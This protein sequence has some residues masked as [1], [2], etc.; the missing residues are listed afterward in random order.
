[1]LNNIYLEKFKKTA[2]TLKTFALAHKII[3]GFI[4]L[5]IIFIGYWIYGK[6]ISTATETQYITT[7]V[8]K[9]SIISSITASGQVESS[10]KIDLKAN[11]SGTITYVSVKPGDKVLQGKTLFIIDNKD[12]QKSVRDAEINLES[13]KISLNKLKIQ[14]SA[15][16]MNTDLA[17]AYDD[18]FNTVSNVFL[19]LPGIMTGLNDMFF[20]SNPSTGQW[21]IDWYEG[22]G[23]H[24][25]VDKTILYKKNLT[26]S[27][28]EARKAYN[29]N[30]EKYKLV[31]RNSEKEIINTMIEETYNTTKL[32]ADVVK[33]ANNY[34]DFIADSMQKNN[35]ETPTLFA[36]H[37]SSLNSYTAKTNSHLINLL[38]TKTNIKTY[39]DAFVNS[40]L[41]IQS[42]ELSVK[43]KENALQDAK[44]KLSDYYVTAP[45]GGIIA[46]ITAKVGDTSSSAL[47]SI[48]TN[49]KI[50]TLSMNEVDVSKIKLGQN[51]IITFDAIEDLSI[52]G[53]VAEIDTIGA[54]SQGVV[55]YS[56][57]ITFDTDNEKIKPG[58]SLSAL[59][60]IESKS[61]IL[62]I[63][64]SAIKTKGSKKYVQMF[65]TPLLNTTPNSQ[66]IQSKEIPIQVIVETGI[67]DDVN[68]EIISGLKEGQQIIS[69]IVTATTT[70]TKTTT[71]SLL[72]G[73]NTRGLSGP[74]GR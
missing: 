67:N 48:I 6:I 12:A 25:D 3:T 34:I 62:K 46:S 37:K 44:D 27:Y 13:A 9:G 65:N 8:K 50:A 14:K 39:T 72:G 36:T 7:V 43:Q 74:M 31:S 69:R 60:T 73:T 63:P 35:Y 66:G 49:Q 28:D 40:D 55:S 5:L 54:T 51:A 4:I 23:D 56:V 38:S 22:L 30:F 58:M 52:T 64:S 19:D 33:N 11:V 53:K 59:I 1:M 24:K 57:K 26:T 29:S 32:I 45:F 47:G 42:S 10:N 17:Q 18:G 41:D 21:N 68:T 71:S 70:T 61:D 16:N 15:E 20:K 2:K